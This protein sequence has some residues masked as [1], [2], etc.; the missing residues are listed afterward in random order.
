MRLTVRRNDTS[1]CSEPPS[2]SAILSARFYATTLLRPCHFRALVRVYASMRACLACHFASEAPLSITKGMVMHSLA[3]SAC[4]R[5]YPD[6]Q[7]LGFLRLVDEDDDDNDDDDDDVGPRY[8]R[9]R[10]KRNS[11]A[12]GIKL[13]R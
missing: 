5:C 13:T 11:R 4:S 8:D 12:R 1:S 3:W 6:T 10:A 9:I 2:L 7:V